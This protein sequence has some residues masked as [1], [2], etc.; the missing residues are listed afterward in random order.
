MPVATVMPVEIG[1]QEKDRKEIAGGLLSLL[2]DTYTLYLKTQ[3]FHW[4]V[5]GPFFQPLH[6]M[7]E[8]QYEELAQ[9]VDQIAERIRA[10]GFF[11]PAT[12]TDFGELSSIDHER[13]A[14]EAEGMIRSL[15]KGRETLVRTAR[16]VLAASERAHDQ[17]TL[18]LLAE[19]M[20]SDEK[21]AWMLRSSINKGEQQTLG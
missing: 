16:M 4:N 21:A 9:A 1:I 19:R 11:V 12:Y 2:A 20:R 17:P 8:T 3:N 5:T 7:F 15:V 6:E 13:G 14:L 18:D 10:L